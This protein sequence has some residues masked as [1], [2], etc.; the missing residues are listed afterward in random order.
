MGCAGV[1]QAAVQMNLPLHVVYL[2]NGDNYKWAFMIYEKRPVLRSA[3]MLARGEI[4]HQ[5]AV[6]AEEQLGA[7]ADQLTF[8]G[9]PDWGTEHIFMEHWSPQAPGLSLDADP[10]HG[11]PV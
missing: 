8:L 10:G 5:E 2:T 11:G 9:Y 7:H 4:R 1:I 6:K 3:E